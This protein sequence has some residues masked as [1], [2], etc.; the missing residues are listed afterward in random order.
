MSN[1]FQKDK[2]DN[3]FTDL[4]DEKIYTKEQLN[5]LTNGKSSDGY[6]LVINNSVD[7]QYL[8]V[9]YSCTKVTTIQIKCNNNLNLQ[10]YSYKLLSGPI[11]ANNSLAQIEKI[12]KVIAG[13]KTTITIYPKDI[14]GNDATNI[15]YE[16][17]LSKIY[18]D[19]SF[20]NSKQNIFQVNVLLKMKLEIITIMR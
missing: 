6:T 15:N 4:F 2:F 3:L 9:Q 8:N 19:Y 5:K 11:N 7:G 18:V 12:Y 14:Y 20:D 16:E 1:L 17:D 10:T 13:D